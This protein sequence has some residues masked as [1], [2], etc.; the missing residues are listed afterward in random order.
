MELKDLSY[1]LVVR[2]TAHLGNAAQALGI[3]QPAL[4]N[5]FSGWKNRARRG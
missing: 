2:E 5:V 1:L 4:T 3:T